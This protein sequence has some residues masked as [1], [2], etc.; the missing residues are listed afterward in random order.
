M[1]DLT[2]ELLVDRPKPPAFSLSLTTSGTFVPVENMGDD[3]LR[4]YDIR[5]VLRVTTFTA[6]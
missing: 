2:N 5:G 1:G 3:R 4:I 6:E